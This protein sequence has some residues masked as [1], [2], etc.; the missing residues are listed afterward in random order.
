MSKKHISLFFICI[1]MLLTIVNPFV[2]CADD[3]ISF[4]WPSDNIKVFNNSEQKYEPIPNKDHIELAYIE[5]TWNQ[6]IN[7]LIP[8]NTIN[9]Y[10]LDFTYSSSNGN[11]VII[12]GS[13]TNYSTNSSYLQINHT[14]SVGGVV[15]IPD[16]IPHLREIAK[17]L[18]C[19]LILNIY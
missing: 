6:G 19:Q 14:G 11:D 18:L 4:S 13:W 8:S 5:S 9:H 10:N 1:L 17:T 15:F 16:L 2:V 12:A 7:T 3:S